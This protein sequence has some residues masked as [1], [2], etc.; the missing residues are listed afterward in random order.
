MRVKVTNFRH[1]Q[2]VHWI[3]TPF[4]AEAQSGHAARKAAALWIGTAGDGQPKS[5]H[6]PVMIRG[7]INLLSLSTA[8]SHQNPPSLQAHGRAVEC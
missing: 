6:A 5:L 3:S 7:L 4:R 8:R 2:G 1:H